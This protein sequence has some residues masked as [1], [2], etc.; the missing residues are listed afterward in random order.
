MI[1]NVYAKFSD[2]EGASKAYN[3]LAGKYYHSI[4]V[5]EEFSPVINFC[6]CSFLFFFF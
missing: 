6:L 4:L 3:A 2:E 5:Q 1:G